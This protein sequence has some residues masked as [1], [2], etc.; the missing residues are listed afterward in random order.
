MNKK[1]GNCLK[2]H[3]YSQIVLQKFKENPNTS[4]RIVSSKL[5]MLIYILDSE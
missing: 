2:L 5:I 4:L 1:K 3:N